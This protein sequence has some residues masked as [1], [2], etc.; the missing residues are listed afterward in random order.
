MKIIHNYP[1]FLYYTAYHSLILYYYSSYCIVFFLTF[2]APLTIF[3]G[4][5]TI[6]TIYPVTDQHYLYYSDSLRVTF[7]SISFKIAY[8]FCCCHKISRTLFFWLSRTKKCN[9][10]C[11]YAAKTKVS[12]NVKPLT[13]L[14]SPLFR[15]RMTLRWSSSSKSSSPSPT[16]CSRHDAKEVKNYDAQQ[17]GIHTRKRME[18]EL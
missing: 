14:F 2:L 7:I 10:T 6:V 5:A 15:W 13:R 11:K 18:V 12:L 1:S 8:E 16:K 9:S 3:S 4:L 17:R